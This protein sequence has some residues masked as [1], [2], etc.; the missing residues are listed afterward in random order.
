MRS[1]SFSIPL[2]GVSLRPSN[3]AGTLDVT[4]TIAQNVLV[5]E[6]GLSGF[7]GP[8]ESIYKSTDGLFPQVPLHNTLLY[9]DSFHYLENSQPTLFGGSV[10]SE[11]WEHCVLNNYIF[12]TND[13][14]ILALKASQTVSGVDGDIYNAICSHYGRVL[15]GGFSGIW[16]T[17]LVNKFPE[18]S[19][20]RLSRS[21]VLWSSPGGKDFFE[22]FTV[23]SYTK[24]DFLNAIRAR[25]LGWIDIPEVG[26]VIKLL[27]LQ[28]KV[29]VYGTQAIAQLTLR[30]DGYASQIVL[31]FG[32]SSKD[33]IVGDIYTH[34]F[35][36]PTDNFW[37]IGRAPSV[38]A[39]ATEHPLIRQQEITGFSPVP[40]R[41][42]GYKEDFSDGFIVKD[43]TREI[44]YISYGSEN[45]TFILSF[46][47]ASTGTFKLVDMI[48][49]EGIYYKT[50][51]DTN[52]RVPIKVEL[53]PVDMGIPNQK[54]LTLVKVGGRGIV[55]KGLRVEVE[56]SLGEKS[57]RKIVALNKD[58]AAYIQLVG[59][60]FKVAV[61]GEILKDQVESVE[62]DYIT[63]VA[64][65]TDKRTLHG[66]GY[67][68]NPSV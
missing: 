52:G 33:M 50:A 53:S 26:E 18:L 10:G 35:Q 11:R 34:L 38:P 13:V 8:P 4:F 5:Q 55:D 47:G 6:W 7:A 66:E 37:I 9:K 15:C 24:E 32:A 12:I 25:T 61:V 43:K 63:L 23:S 16:P 48:G 68:I 56:A 40:V 41:R 44:F 14:R 19:S 22:L 27:P 59:S 60:T 65:A 42:L 54:T 64:Q 67:K 31:D 17:N 21:T 58:G 36:D 28:N 39:P 62:L 49:T 3:R 57:R 51:E 20:N 45:K 2:K 1:F 46:D 29:I 30:E